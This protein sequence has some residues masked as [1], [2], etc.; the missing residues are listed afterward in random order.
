MYDRRLVATGAAIAVVAVVALAVMVAAPR[1]L[2]GKLDALARQQL[3]RS[4][5]ATGGAHLDFLPLSL[6]LEGATLSGATADGDSLVTAK[7]ATLPVTL[8]Q[9]LGAAPALA[10]I[11]LAEPEFALLIDE[12]GEASWDFP[13]LTPAG[14]LRLKLEEGRMRYFDARNS[15]SLTLGRLNGTLDIRADGG[16]SYSGT[17]VIN[18][19]L[20]RI[21]ADLKS[22]ARVNADGSPL[23]VALAADDGA[24]S[25]SGRLATGQVLSLAGPVS[26]SSQSPAG[27]LR[28]VGLPL[29]EGTKVTGPV[30]VDG[31]LDSA[32][33]A[34]AIRNATLS[35]GAFQGLGELGADLRNAVPKLQ[36]HLA[37]DTLW[38]D[39]FL[40]AVGAKDGDWGRL[41]LPFG[42]LKGFD[43]EAAIDTRHLD[44]GRFT[45]DGSQVKLALAGGKLSLTTVSDVGE[46]GTLN[47]TATVDAAATPPAV[48][49]NIVANDVAAQPLLGALTGATGLT[50]TGGFS[51]DVTASGTTQEEL[52]GMMKGSASLDFVNG[53]IAGVDLAGLML[54]AKDKTMEGWSAAPGG[55]PFSRI[56]AEGTIADGI[57]SF[58]NATIEGATASFTVEGLI[59]A[60]RQGI[61]VSATA[62]ANGQP[63]LPV[64]II[65][66]GPWV[67]PKIYPDIPSIITNPAAGGDTKQDAL[68]QPK[69]IVPA[70]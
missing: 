19:R 17:A 64:A 68:P 4:V 13:G 2:M 70:N 18:D 44:L 11:T 54:A 34:F 6:R 16:A 27:A 35:V 43:A 39:S 55:T 50:G 47:V 22:L 9:I 14:G 30:T 56:A 12:R 65:A 58:R 24:A 59:D 32:G 31:A 57:A 48:A 62:Q 66:R 61:A 15:Q 8:G 63:L 23:E 53:E 7:T 40:P 20:V 69:A 42:L 60:L 36:A 26:L 41:P 3:G 46:D 5:A 67:K 51:A 21:D 33:R 49:V 45:A 28:L 1:S 37:A 52:I 38:L 25:F 10:E 29:P